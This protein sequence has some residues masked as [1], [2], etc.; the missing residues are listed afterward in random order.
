MSYILHLLKRKHR[1]MVSFNNLR[2]ITNSGS[3]DNS[4][5]LKVNT[6]KV[7]HIYMYVGLIKH[8]EYFP[9]SFLST[10]RV[11]IQSY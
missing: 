3:P 8:E 7:A 11:Q 1:S 6:K 9:T 2:L 10:Q 5:L 4:G